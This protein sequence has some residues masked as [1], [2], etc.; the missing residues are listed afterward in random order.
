M[1]PLFHGELR[2]LLALY[3]LKALFPT[4]PS[5]GGISVHSSSETTVDFRWRKMARIR[6]FGAWIGLVC[7]PTSLLWLASSGLAQDRCAPQKLN[8]EALRGDAAQKDWLLYQN[9]RTGLSF[10][11]PST[12]RI[13]ERDPTTFHFDVVPTVIVD[14]KGD[15]PNDPNITPLR[16]ICAE[17]RKT[18][19]AAGAKA[20]ALLRTHP[21]ENSSGRV[22]DGAIGTIQVDGH[23]AVLSCGCGRAACQY[24]IQTL[25]PYECQIF[26]MVS[27]EGF[28]DNYPPPHDGTFPILSIIKTIHFN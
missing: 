19:E 15:E 17:G 25:Q 2:V 11:Y 28:F 27:G 24:S 1:F 8:A 21:E 3:Y 9:H 23:E 4:Y 26:P 10:R 16:I 20:R 18:A 14:L 7:V 22:A 12:M 5:R 13:E 6:H